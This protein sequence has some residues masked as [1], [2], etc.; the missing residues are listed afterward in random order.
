MTKSNDERAGVDF[1]DFLFTVSI[2]AGLTP[3]VLEVPGI[4]GLLSEDWQQAGRWPSTDEVFN[5][6][7][8]LLGL[9]NLTLSWFGYHASVKARP[10]NYFSGYGMV[11]FV[12]DVILVIM[13]GIML[14]KYKS[15]NV[16][17]SLLLMVYFIF[18]VWDYLKVCEYWEKEFQNKKK[19]ETLFKRYRREWISVFAFANVAVI[20][21]F[22]F[23]LH[24]NRWTALMLAIFITVFYRYNKNHRAS[25][26]RLFE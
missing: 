6:G 14:I 18:V 4:S 12:L 21:I 8:Y 25:W 19:T 15:F 5:I 2:S 17:L 24:T 3:E 26:E 20:A 11:R 10:L 13:Y 9:L 7:V 22:Y 16:S 23:A 1:L